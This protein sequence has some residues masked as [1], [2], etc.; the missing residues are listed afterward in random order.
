MVPPYRIE[1]DLKKHHSRNGLRTIFLL[2]EGLNTEK[3]LINPL[4]SSNS[5]V[6]KGKMRFRPITKEDNDV[7]IT[8]P[9]SLVKYAKHF[10]KN[11]INKGNFL[12][13]RDKVMIVFDL[14][15]FNNNQ[16]QMDKLLKNK[17]NDM[18][19]CYTNPAIELFLLLTVNQGYE[20]IVE[21]NKDKILAN[22]KNDR[23]ERYVYSL[24]LEKV[25]GYS[26]SADADFRFILDNIDNALMQ[27]KHI[28]NKISK[29]ANKLT[30]NIAYLLKKFDNNDFDIEY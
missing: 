6:K 23:G 10:I 29:A 17:T 24:A 19:F 30:S 1:A 13:G 16:S 5:I 26:K 8:N 15:V 14:D 4:L 27:E 18:I 3:Y 28:N 9:F 7:G 22:E 2:Y 21:P 25:P 20:Q 11:E 12:S